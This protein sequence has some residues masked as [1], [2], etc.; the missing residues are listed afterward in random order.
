[1]THGIWD[2]MPE[3]TPTCTIG[4]PMPES[5]LTLCRSRLYP[6]VRDFGFCLWG[7]YY[8]GDVGIKHKL[9]PLQHF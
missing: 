9:R 7:H 1:M 4:N 5:I 2:P 3:S 8:H 6:P